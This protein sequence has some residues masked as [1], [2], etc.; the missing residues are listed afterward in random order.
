[1]LGSEFS[2]IAVSSAALSS[3]L[4]RTGS[5]EEAAAARESKAGG[6]WFVGGEALAI[7]SSRAGSENLPGEGG[8]VGENRAISASRSRAK[9]VDHLPGEEAVNI[10]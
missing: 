5:F 4:A 1:M 9:S 2:F 7:Q 10:F 8:E 3:V 6:H